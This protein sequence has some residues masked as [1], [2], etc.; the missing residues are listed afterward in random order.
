MSGLPS[1]RGRERPHP[2]R[3]APRGEMHALTNSPL[4]H[5]Q[6]VT[7]REERQLD[8]GVVNGL[9]DKA[10]TYYS[11]PYSADYVFLRKGS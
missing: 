10:G 1:V 4:Q 5:L 2:E 6:L 7:H 11:A 8:G 9:C 3:A